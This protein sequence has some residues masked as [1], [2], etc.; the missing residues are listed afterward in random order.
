M[1]SLARQCGGRTHFELPPLL[2]SNENVIDFLAQRGDYNLPS[3]RRAVAA[4]ID[5]W[6]KGRY[7]KAAEFLGIGYELLRQADGDD[8]YLPFLQA[9]VVR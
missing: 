8:L 5:P 9:M 7:E 2:S 3:A 1:P 4:A 6:R